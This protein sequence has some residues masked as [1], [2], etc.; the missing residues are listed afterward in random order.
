MRI[1]ICYRVILCGTAE[2]DLTPLF[3]LELHQSTNGFDKRFHTIRLRNYPQPVDKKK[4]QEIFLSFWSICGYSS[5]AN[6][7]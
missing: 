7:P 2:D 5:E 4:G 1:L 6:T 3:L